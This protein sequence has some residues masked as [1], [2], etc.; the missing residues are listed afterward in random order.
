M[1]TPTKE[2]RLKLRYSQGLGDI[3]ACL[4]HS[5]ALGWL[6]KLISGKDAP[7]EMCSKRQDALNL[8]FPIPLW[9]LFFKDLEA[10]VTDM[11]ERYKEAGMPASL[12][13]SPN[14]NNFRILTGIENYV[15]QDKPVKNNGMYNPFIMDAKLSEYKLVSTSDS[16][17]DHI[18]VRTQIYKK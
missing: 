1:Q 11:V 9:K 3:I 7:C 15:P 2:P 4:L 13:K 12:V 10:A 8:L 16:E 5:K 18:L 6:T 17:A 14:S